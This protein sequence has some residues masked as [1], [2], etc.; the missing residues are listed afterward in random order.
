MDFEQEYM[1]NLK[2]KEL[3]TVD[4]YDIRLLNDLKA[5]YRTMDTAEYPSLD[6]FIEEMLKEPIRD[7]WVLCDKEGNLI[8]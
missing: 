8:N 4:E 3:I 5:W 6:L 7:S 2:T 1:I